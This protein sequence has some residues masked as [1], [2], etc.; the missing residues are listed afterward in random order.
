M[1]VR[2]S[3]EATGVLD[4]TLPPAQ[5]NGAVLGKLKRLRA[6]YNLATDGAVTTSDQILLGRL[7][8]GAVFAF[9][10]LTSDTSFNTSV[11]A[12][13][14][15]ATHASNNKYR[16]AAAFTAVQTPTPFGNVA[17]QGAAPLTAPEDVWMTVATANLP[18]TGIFTVDIFYSDRV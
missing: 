18:S 13:G 12:I 4:G 11:V 9:G 10:M 5:T 15:S 2:Y 6:T 16:T 1:A 14:A 7:P 17:A 3:K 8:A